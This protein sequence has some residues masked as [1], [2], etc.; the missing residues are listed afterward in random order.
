MGFI[1]RF[2]L[3]ITKA[4]E[5]YSNSGAIR[6]A[7]HQSLLSWADRALD[8]LDAMELPPGMDRYGA[9]QAWDKYAMH[10]L[11]GSKDRLHSESKADALASRAAE[12]F[13]ALCEVLLDA[14]ERNAR[15]SR[16]PWAGS[17]GRRPVHTGRPAIGLTGV[18][19]YWHRARFVSS[20]Q[21]RNATRTSRVGSA[22]RWVE[23]SVGFCL[24]L[25]N[26]LGLSS[27][28]SGG[29]VNS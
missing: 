20:T 4:D 29:K 28:R 17:R 19:E 8:L 16:V 15:A 13:T 14:A 1:A 25:P 10:E 5:A 6:D 18:Q 26:L 9:L 2:V 27:L 23:C 12:K 3:M 22:I 7:F 21:R 24:F 11:I